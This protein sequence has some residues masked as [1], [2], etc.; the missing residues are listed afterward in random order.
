LFDSDGQKRAQPTDSQKASIKS[1][2]V[3]K[4][5]PATDV[6]SYLNQPRFRSKDLGSIV[7]AD[8]DDSTAGA[9]S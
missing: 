2:R 5:S 9:S 4:D 1:L 8:S 6:A 7:E 3:L